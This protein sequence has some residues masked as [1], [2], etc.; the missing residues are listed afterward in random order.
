MKQEEL[1]KRCREI[2]DHIPANCTC[3]N[4]RPGD[5]IRAFAAEIAPLV[6]ALVHIGEY[7]NGNNASAVDAA[8]ECSSSATEALANFGK[9]D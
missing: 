4:L 3:G 6:E 8:E 1:L 9:P 2:T 5:V 7:W